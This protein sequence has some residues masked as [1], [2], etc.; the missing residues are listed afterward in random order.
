MKSYLSSL[1]LSELTIRNMIEMCPNVV[2]LN[3]NE[4]REKTYILQKVNCT[5]EQIKNIISSNPNY[6]NRTNDDILDLIKTLLDFGFK[7]LNILFDGNPYILNL[8]S[9]EI[10]KYV[11]I[12]IEAGETLDDVIDDLDSNPYLFNEM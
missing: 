4:I 9:F 3:D 7:S 12:R 5:H 10:K 11:N 2:E 6:L 1:N 8:D